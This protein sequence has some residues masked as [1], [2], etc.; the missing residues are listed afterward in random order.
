VEA[1]A[2]SSG[3]TDARAEIAKRFADGDRWFATS[4]LYQ[5]LARTVASDDA[6]LDLAAEAQPGQQPANMLMAA[7]LDAI[8]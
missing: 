3:V 4:P 5:V 7:T 6:L 2:A 8:R 1:L